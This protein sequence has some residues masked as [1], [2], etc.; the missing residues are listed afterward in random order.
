MKKILLLLVIVQTWLK[1][2]LAGSVSTKSQLQKT[3][4]YL[5]I[6]FFA[7]LT[8]KYVYT[9]FSKRVLTEGMVGIYNTQT[10]PTTITNLISQPL[11]AFDSQGNL[12]P[13]LAQSW[14]VSEDATTYTLTLKDN[15]SW[16]DGTPLKSQDLMFNLPDDVSVTYPN[17]T[18]IQ[19]KLTE[20]YSPLLTLLTN[21][22]FKG[23]SLIGTNGYKVRSVDYNQD[24]V[25][26]ISLTPPNTRL[27]EIIIR[28]YPDERTLKTAFDLG[29]VDS[30]IG[31]ADILAY[32]ALKN[33]Q[34]SKIG[35]SN[36]LVAVFYNMKDPILSDRNLR[37][38]LSYASPK[39]TGEER[40]K[41]P[42]ANSSWAYNDSAR[43]ALDNLDL[44]QSYL[45]KA[46]YDKSQIIL[47]TTPAL[48]P[49][50]ES[51]IEGWKRVGI[52]GAVRVESG[53]PQNFQALLI[54]EAIPQDPDQYALWHSTQ[55]T[56]NL[57]K[58]SSPRVDKDLEDARKATDVNVRKERYADF[59]KVIVDDSP[60]TFL[61]FPKPNLIF[62]NKVKFLIEQVELQQFNAP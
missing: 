24:I 16:S 51:V 26:R 33:V 42:I 47:T 23:K 39:I 45:S 35:V 13:K 9:F 41:T 11:V 60:A 12:Q 21:P 34:L 54:S 32:K 56:T 8:I 4:L 48:E 19:F 30:L 49:V 2:V 37:L 36:H 29:E 44:A 28:F 57:T 14:Q 50:A 22:V 31:P 58:Y 52:D 40:A 18:T 61:Y 5:L 53:V 3:A 62:R 7:L 27:P 43:D 46:H 38:A 6:L 25:S 10:L 55:T 1:R 20:S 17:A 59:Q 15:L